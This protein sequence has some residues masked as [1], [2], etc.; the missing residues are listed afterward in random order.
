MCS[1]GLRAGQVP[2]RMTWSPAVTAESICW[3]TRVSGGADGGTNTAT[4]VTPGAR[5]RTSA[6]GEA[7]RWPR[8]T[9]RRSRTSSLVRGPYFFTEWSTLLPADRRQ[10]RKECPQCVLQENDSLSRMRWEGHWKWRLT[11]HVVPIT[12]SF[13]DFVNFTV[14][15]NFNHTINFSNEFGTTLQLRPIMLLNL[16]SLTKCVYLSPFKAIRIKFTGVC[17]PL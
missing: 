9:R 8:Y 5:L 17:F 16:F 2:S 13:S 15:I 6:E 10:V 1:P 4:T 11:R 3:A 7:C 14:L 12:L